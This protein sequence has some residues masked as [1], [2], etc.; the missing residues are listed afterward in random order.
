METLKQA[1]YANKADSVKNRTVCN[2]GIFY[3]TPVTPTIL[4]N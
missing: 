2:D 4:K 3:Y 1:N